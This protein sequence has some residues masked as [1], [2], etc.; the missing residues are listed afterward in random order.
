VLGSKVKELLDSCGLKCNALPV[1]KQDVSLDFHQ[2]ILIP[3]IRYQTRLCDGSLQAQQSRLS[4]ANLSFEHSRTPPRRKSARRKAAPP[5]PSVREQPF[6][7]LTSRAMRR[8]LPPPPQFCSLLMTSDFPTSTGGGGGGH[9]ERLGTAAS[10][11]RPSTNGTSAT[12]DTHPRSKIGSALPRDGTVPAQLKHSD[13]V[14]SRPRPAGTPVQ[15]VAVAAR[16]GDTQA[17]QRADTGMSDDAGGG[18][19]GVGC[20]VPHILPL[21]WLEELD[22]K[23]KHE[24]LASRARQRDGLAGIVSVSNLPP[25]RA[26]TADVESRLRGALAATASTQRPESRA[27]AGSRARRVAAATHDGERPAWTP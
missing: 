16:R 12:R 1:S 19:G 23:I 5:S 14:L 22:R 15:A 27:A 13:S 17:M 20:A 3:L 11:S 9:N 2:V 10:G 21:K 26:R 24:R 25:A 8:A 7:E 4:T 18:G 6:H